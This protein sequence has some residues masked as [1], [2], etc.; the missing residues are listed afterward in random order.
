MYAIRSYYADQRL[1]PK[2]KD[3]LLFTVRHGGNDGRIDI[4]FNMYNWNANIVLTLDRKQL[5]WDPNWFV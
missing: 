3:D 4:G 5:G 1:D 2:G